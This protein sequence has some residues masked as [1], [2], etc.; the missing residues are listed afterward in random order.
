MLDGSCLLSQ[1]GAQFW[2]DFIDTH[3]SLTVI[4]A[5]HSLFYNL[6]DWFVGGSPQTSCAPHTHIPTKLPSHTALSQQ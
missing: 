2:L 3:L 6:C 4:L 1:W 5:V